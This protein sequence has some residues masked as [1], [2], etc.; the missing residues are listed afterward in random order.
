M[1]NNDNNDNNNSNS[2]LYYPY[3]RYLYLPSIIEIIITI[4]YIQCDTN[5]ND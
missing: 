3:W 4:G 5:D 1:D 2:I